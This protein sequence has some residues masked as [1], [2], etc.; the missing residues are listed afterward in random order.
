MASVI[1]AVIVSP[2]AVTLHSGFELAPLAP[3]WAMLPVT[4]E[5]L[6]RLDPAAVGDARIPD[7]WSLKQPV[8]VLAR[9]MSARRTA[10]YLYS[11]TFGGPGS[12]EAIGW[13]DGSLLYGPSGTCDIEADLQPGYHRAHGA[14]PH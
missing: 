8:T 4:E 5:L 13:K 6:A 12:S 9:V 3:G 10:L 1:E 2:G 7:G 11:E 14:T